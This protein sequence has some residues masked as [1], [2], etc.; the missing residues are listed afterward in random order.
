MNGQIIAR[1]PYPGPDGKKVWMLLGIVTD[2]DNQLK[3]GYQ[4]TI[5]MAPVLIHPID[6]EK[7]LIGETPSGILRMPIWRI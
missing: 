2:P 3:N 6:R 1:G 5:G 7:E 4:Y